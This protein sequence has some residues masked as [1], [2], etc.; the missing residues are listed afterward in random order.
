MRNDRKTID[1]FLSVNAILLLLLFWVGSLIIN[2][3]IICESVCVWVCVCCTVDVCDVLCISG[4]YSKLAAGTLLGRFT[5]LL[6]PDRSISSKFFLTNRSNPLR[7]ISS[8]FFLTNRSNPLRSISSKFLFWPPK[9]TPLQAYK[10]KEKKKKEYKYC[11]QPILFGIQL[12]IG[13][14]E[15]KLNIFR[16]GR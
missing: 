3:I 10:L 2:N 13:L 7:S 14:L 16:L 12:I 8:K 1:F 11:D 5:K 9:D 6:N 15:I 4:V